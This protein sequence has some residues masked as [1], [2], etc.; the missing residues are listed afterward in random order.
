MDF[1]IKYWLEAIFGLA[2]AGLSF[3]CKSLFKNMKKKSNEQDA[4]KTGIV[5]VLHDRVYQEC[6]QYLSIGYI[7]LDKAEEILDNLKILYNAYH[8]L[9]GNGTGTNIYERTI[10]LPLKNAED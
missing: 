8:D 5:A 4:I 7:P 2:L 1:L 6:N 9:G 3:C 10:K